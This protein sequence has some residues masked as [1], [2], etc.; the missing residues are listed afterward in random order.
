MRICRPITPLQANDQITLSAW[1][2]DWLHPGQL[3]QG[4]G[5]ATDSQVSL[6]CW[7]GGAN[8]TCN[9]VFLKGYNPR[10]NK[11]VLQR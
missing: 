2:G 6:C 10:E 3:P 8:T 7:G 5:E 4:S 11:L 9:W 1:L